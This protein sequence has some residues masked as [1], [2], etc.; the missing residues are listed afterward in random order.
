M[1][2]RRKETIVRQIKLHH[3]HEFVAQRTA[4]TANVRSRVLV[5]TPPNNTFITV[6]RVLQAV[7]K[8]FAVGGAQVDP[9]TRVFV[10]KRRPGES[11]PTFLPGEFTLQSFYDLSTAEQRNAENRVTLGQD[12]GSG[13]LLR[14]QEELI[15]EVEGPDVIDWDNTGTAFEFTAGWQAN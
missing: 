1:K 9:N 3:R 10:G 8:L 7:I 12:L 15:I 14:E 2:A 4:N 11:S 13:I 6:E 5:I